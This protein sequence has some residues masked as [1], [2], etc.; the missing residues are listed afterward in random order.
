M[1]MW[2][3]LPEL[4]R[5]NVLAPW[6]LGMAFGVFVGGTPGLTAT[7]A[8]ALLAPLSFKMEPS[9]GIAMVIGVSFTAIFAG[10]LPA[11]F[12]RIPGTPASAAATLDGYALAK[13]G[14]GWFAV[15]LDLFCSSAGGLVGVGLLIWLAPLMGRWALQFSDFERV[16]LGV[17]GLS[18]SIVVSRG[19]PLKG[20]AMALLG[21]LLSTVGADVRGPQRFSLGMP[22]LYGGLDFIAIMIGV[23][24][25]AEVFRAVQA[26]ES[27]A[28][29]TPQNRGGPAVRE[30]LAA[31]FRNLPTFFRSSILG[32]FIG[33]LPGAGADIAAWAAYGVAKRVSS[34]GERFGEGC[35][36]GVVAPTSANNAAVA[37][38]WI[39]A[40]VFGVPGD[41][42]TAIVLG[43]LTVYG[44]QAGPEVFQTHTRQIHAIF[45]IALITQILLIPAGL[46]GCWAFGWI[47]RLPR[48]LL[49]AS[50]VLF[51][52][53]GAYSL[54]NRMFDVVVA[55]VA[56]LFGYYAEGRRAPLPPLVLG[57]I[58][59]GMI[60]ENLRTGLISH[61]GDWS[62]L[63]TRPICAA[64]A[65]AFVAM[66]T[67]PWLFS[68][69]R[70]GAAK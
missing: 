39:P 49:I 10:D 57:L 66:W 29:Q 12:L 22:E 41:A 27:E 50:I 4:L 36:Q 56:G 35:E 55:C 67:L 8:V 2:E 17:I 15:T 48:K 37:G 21:L 64:L 25:L 14:R 23:F 24:G 16:W 38:A 1:M 62:A 34:E 31:L 70:G 19:Q 33:A 3:A 5:W 69:Q 42:V 44:I 68:R 43:S 52:L 18:L 30:A 40:L 59:G 32:A 20:A 46:L 11:T 9:A 60:E 53:V 13:K 45:A 65:L 51:S 6:V 61:R 7:M 58:L 47:L 54:N 28:T 26:R 63:F